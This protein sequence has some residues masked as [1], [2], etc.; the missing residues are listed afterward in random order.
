[1][2]VPLDSSHDQPP[3]TEIR[4][5]FDD[6]IKEAIRSHDPKY[7]YDIESTL[8]QM[9]RKN[10]HVYDEYFTQLDASINEIE[11]SEE[12]KTCGEAISTLP[13]KTGKGRKKEFLFALDEACYVKDE[14]KT[15]R[16]ASYFME[17]L[18]KNGWDSLPTSS[19]VDSPLNVAIFSFIRHWKQNGCLPKKQVVGANTV[20]RFL[21]E[22]CQIR[23]DATMKSFYN[24]FS[25]KQ[26]KEVPEIEK[27]V[28]AYF[29]KNHGINN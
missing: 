28:E 11:H 27:K 6:F 5:I 24:V 3:T 19:K 4:S 23:I 20:F 1:M 9:S 25:T 18:K 22:D 7:L 13:K 17:F 26:A 2:A 14:E 21:T 10:G 29:K 16:M 15:S 8:L 12:Q